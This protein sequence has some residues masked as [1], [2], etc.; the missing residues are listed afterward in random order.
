MIINNELEMERW[1]K[2]IDHAK[3]TQIGTRGNCFKPDRDPTHAQMLIDGIIKLNKRKRSCFFRVKDVDISVT[4]R[5][6]QHIA[7]FLVEL[8][9]IKVYS[10]NSNGVRYRIMFDIDKAPRI[11]SLGGGE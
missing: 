3:K 1:M 8:G 9:L 11:S 4:L 7:W 10:N 2:F 5:K 6:R